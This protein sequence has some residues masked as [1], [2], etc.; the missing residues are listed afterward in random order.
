MEN[1]KELAKNFVIDLEELIKNQNNGKFFIDSTEI[2]ISDAL[3]A[4]TQLEHITSCK[5]IKNIP[6]LNIPNHKLMEEYSE[7]NI[8]I[9]QLKASL[10]R[11]NNEVVDLDV[12]TKFAFVVNAAEEIYDEV[13]EKIQENA[14]SIQLDFGEVDSNDLEEFFSRIQTIFYAET[15]D[16]IPDL[17]DINP[18]IL[19][20]YQE[21]AFFVREL[22]NPTMNLDNF[23]QAE[24]S[25]SY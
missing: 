22:K 25:L 9:N 6:N 13:Q 18:I 1:I 12:Q 14:K 5:D 15:A 4:I 10:D 2:E 16:E 24:A 17:N 23:L 8:L 21:L 3:E 11:D 20:E 19:E 7:L